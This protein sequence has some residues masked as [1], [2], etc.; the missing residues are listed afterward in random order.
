VHASSDASELVIEGVRVRRL[1]DAL[2]LTITLRGRFWN[3]ADQNVYV[4]LGSPSVQPQRYALSEDPQFFAESAYPIRSAMTL[5]HTIDLR[6]GV[7]SPEN[8]AYSPQVYGSDRAPT[9]RVGPDAHIALASEA[10]EVRLRLPVAEYYRGLG[11]NVP[12]LLAVTVATARDY[13][14]F[15]DGRTVPNLRIGAEGSA[16]AAP[17]P[18]AIYPQIDHASHELVS[19]ALDREGGA[20]AITLQTRAAITDW[21]QTNIHFFLIAEPPSNSAVRVFD[22][23]HTTSLPYPWSYY[24]GVYS[25]GRVYCRSSAGG[26]FRYDAAYSE[27][28]ELAAPSGVSFATLG[29]A[30]Y[31]LFIPDEQ[32]RSLAPSGIAVIVSIGQDGRGPSTWY[33]S[34]PDWAR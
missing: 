13:V 15:I 5:Q 29:P 18:P 21:A 22:P 14:G 2:E 12:E 23:S 9:I 6:V 19:V 25:P 10:H 33:G 26:D 16:D 3:Q 20:L 24:C 7:M 27:R 4:F 8:A 28:R 1:A 11:Q 30:K 32:L 17:L 31:A 34:R